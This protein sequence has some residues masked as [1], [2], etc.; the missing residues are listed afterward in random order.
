MYAIISDR[1]RQV[2]VREGEVVDLDWNGAWEPEQKI[3]FEQVLL[4]AHE[5]E[6]KLGKPVL[7]GASVEA[8]VL[9]HVQGDKLVL[10][11]FRRRKGVRRKRGHRQDFTRVKVTKIEA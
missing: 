8:E 1:T 3:R 4:V 7:N 9:G 6:T 5:G 11:R 2:T 10:F